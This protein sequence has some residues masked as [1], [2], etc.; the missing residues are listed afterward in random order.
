[1]KWSRRELLTGLVG[2]A[3]SVVA[4]PG[5]ARARGIRVMGRAGDLVPGQVIRV[6]WPPDQDAAGAYIVHVV[7]RHE[8][9]TAAAPEPSGLFT[10]VMEVQA[11]PPDGRLRPGRHDFYL[12][13]H[14]RR[15]WLGGYDV[16]R[17]RFGF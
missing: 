1:M 5:T 11:F 9:G 13:T 7:D 6:V 8:V 17:F 12:E 4:L 14:G 15:L 3:A 2:A 10:Q 16:A